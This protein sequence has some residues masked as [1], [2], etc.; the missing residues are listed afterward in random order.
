MKSSPDC[1]SFPG[2][3]RGT[4]IIQGIDTGHRTQDKKRADFNNSTPSVTTNYY[5][6]ELTVWHLHIWKLHL[7]TRGDLPW[8]S[9]CWVWSASPCLW[10]LWLEGG[11]R[12]WHLG[13]VAAFTSDALFLEAV[14]LAVPS[15]TDWSSLSLLLAAGKKTAEMGKTA[16][17]EKSNFLSHLKPVLLCQEINMKVLVCI[18]NWKAIGVSA[19]PCTCFPILF[20]RHT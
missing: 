20:G 9:R 13:E 8:L 18:W 3:L 17:K 19:I 7:Y 5:A 4:E 2:Q 10:Y 1:S 11:D 15:T 6:N 12:P 16:M 14:D